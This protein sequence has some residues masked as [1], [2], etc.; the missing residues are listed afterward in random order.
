MDESPE[1]QQDG[2]PEMSEERTE[3]S[4]P[5]AENGHSSEGHVQAGDGDS[6]TELVIDV[7]PSEATPAKTAP[8]ILKAID[9]AKERD[10]LLRSW[11]L[12]SGVLQEALRGRSALEKHILDTVR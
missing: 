7:E 8:W 9:E 4:A 11:D 2:R 6:Q 3:Y 12:R 1:P 5:L 10:R